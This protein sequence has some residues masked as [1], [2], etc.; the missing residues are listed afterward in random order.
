L[1]G[2]NMPARKQNSCKNRLFNAQIAK[3]CSPVLKIIANEFL[4][5]AKIMF[6]N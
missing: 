2:K 6:V 1:K 3:N 5:L 4:L